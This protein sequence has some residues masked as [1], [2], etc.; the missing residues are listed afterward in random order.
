MQLLTFCALYRER[1][2][3]LL[4]RCGVLLDNS[5]LRCLVDSLVGSR[6]RLGSLLGVSGD[7]LLYRLRRFGKCALTTDVIH[8]LLQAR[9]V[10]LLS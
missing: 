2:T 9:A 7:E 3:G 5:A 10:R 4:A 8:V 1:K 6:K